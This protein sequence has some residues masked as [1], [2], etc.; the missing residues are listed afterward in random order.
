MLIRYAKKARNPIVVS[1]LITLESGATR[2]SQPVVRIA[3]AQSGVD[4]SPVE[5]AAEVVRSRQAERMCRRRRRSPV[6]SGASSCAIAI[7][8]TWDA[9]ARVSPTATA[10]AR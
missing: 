5:D 2:P 3:I 9:V 8:F 4:H 1:P 10:M 6:Y 7:V